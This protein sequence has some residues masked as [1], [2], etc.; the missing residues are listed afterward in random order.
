[1]QEPIQFDYRPDRLLEPILETVDAAAAR[2]LGGEV[3]VCL[4]VGSM[5]GRPWAAR[6]RSLP[7]CLGGP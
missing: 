4:R 2:L 6:I 3:R 7:A 5:S 1:M